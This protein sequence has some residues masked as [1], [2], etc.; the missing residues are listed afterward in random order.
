VGSA[1]AAR[2]SVHDPRAALIDRAGSKVLWEKKPTLCGAKL[3]TAMTPRG[4]AA[5][6]PGGTAVSRREFMADP[7]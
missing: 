6:V 3:L 1:P 5:A 4:D 7:L 2:R